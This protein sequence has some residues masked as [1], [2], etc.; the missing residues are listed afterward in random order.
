MC[1]S[2]VA[3]SFSLIFHEGCTSS[4]PQIAS[5]TLAVVAVILDEGDTYALFH[6]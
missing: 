3:S 1:L 5:S 2:A 6:V 4:V